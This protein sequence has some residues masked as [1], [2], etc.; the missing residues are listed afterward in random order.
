M[1]ELLKG[2]LRLRDVDEILWC[3]NAQS[4][5]GFSCFAPLKISLLL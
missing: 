1:E 2:N 4:M 3:N 5:L